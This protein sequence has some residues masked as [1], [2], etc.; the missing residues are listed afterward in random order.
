[1]ADFIVR[2]T[3]R[4]YMSDEPQVPQDGTTDPVQPAEGAATEAAPTPEEETPAA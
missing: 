2:L 4:K 3:F 1:M